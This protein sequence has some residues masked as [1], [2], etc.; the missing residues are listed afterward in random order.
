MEGGDETSIPQVSGAF[1]DKRIIVNAFRF[2]KVSLALKNNHC[3]MGHL[4]KHM[5]TRTLKHETASFGPENIIFRNFDASVDVESQLV[6]LAR[7]SFWVFKRRLRVSGSVELGSTISAASPG[8]RTV[9]CSAEGLCIVIQRKVFQEGRNQ[10][11]ARINSRSV[12]QSLRLEHLY[13]TVGAKGKAR[14]GVG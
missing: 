1:S 11:H 13:A 5:L 9:M 3:R 4:G 8:F 2:Y 12:R 6:R 7:T 14:L 10:S